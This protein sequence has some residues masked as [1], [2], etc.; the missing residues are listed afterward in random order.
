MGPMR[1]C[2]SCTAPLTDP[3]FQG[4]AEDYCKHCTDEQG[5]LK[6]R[7]EVQRAIAAW[8]QMWQPDL[9]EQTALERAGFFMQAMPAWAD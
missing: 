3:M 2:H 7:H 6:D 8:F 4:P 1:F 5:N 9:N